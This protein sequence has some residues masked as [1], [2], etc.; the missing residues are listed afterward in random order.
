MQNNDKKIKYA[1]GK[2]KTEKSKQIKKRSNM[3]ESQKK[4]AISIQKDTQSIRKSLA[5]ALNDEGKIDML[6]LSEQNQPLSEI[7][8]IILM[9]KTGRDDPIPYAKEVA[10]MLAAR[11]KGNDL[12]NALSKLEKLMKKK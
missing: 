12:S 7:F 9:S 6:K 10:A 3:K 8:D 2:L 5:N 1:T 11:D 4:S